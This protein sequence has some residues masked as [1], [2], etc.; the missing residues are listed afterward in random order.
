MVHGSRACSWV[1]LGT[2][3]GGIFN[4][5]IPREVKVGFEEGVKAEIC[6][7]AQPIACIGDVVIIPVDDVDI[8]SHQTHLQVKDGMVCTV[9]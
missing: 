1:S 7:K 8:P 9:V 5:K 6:A 4:M 3:S 2:R